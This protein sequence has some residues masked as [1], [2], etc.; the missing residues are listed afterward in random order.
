M[1]ILGVPSRKKIRIWTNYVLYFQNYDLIVR[2]VDN[3]L[4]KLDICFL[5][6]PRRLTV[7]FWFIDSSVL[8]L[9]V[10]FYILTVQFWFLTQFSFKFIN[11]S[12]LNL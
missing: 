1:S 7:Q 10:Q 4:P 12:V 8:Y 9:T 5:R 6:W 3:R 11:S 2:F